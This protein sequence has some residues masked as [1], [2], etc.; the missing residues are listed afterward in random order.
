MKVWVVYKEYCTSCCPEDGVNSGTIFHDEAF[1]SEEKAEEVMG[2]LN[3]K[4]PGL[5]SHDGPGWSMREFE[6]KGD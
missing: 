4:K 2:E 3:S 6:V 5:Y 1:T